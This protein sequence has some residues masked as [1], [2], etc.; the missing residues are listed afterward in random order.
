MQQLAEA[1]VVDGR[2]GGEEMFI[3]CVHTPYFFVAY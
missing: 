2:G 1:E 3:F